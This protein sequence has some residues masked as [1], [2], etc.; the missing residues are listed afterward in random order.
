MDAI[1]MGIRISSYEISGGHKGWDHSRY[2]GELA[3]PPPVAVVTHTPLILISC[4][5]LQPFHTFYHSGFH[6][7]RSVKCQL[8][9]IFSLF[10]VS[11]SPAEV[12]GTYQEVQMCPFLQRSFSLPLW[13]FIPRARLEGGRGWQDGKVL[14]SLIYTVLS[15]P[16]GGQE[17]L[18]WNSPWLTNVSLVG[19]P[20]D[21][22]GHSQVGDIRLHLFFLNQGKCSG[23]H[24]SPPAVVT[25]A[26]LPRSASTFWR[27]LISLKSATH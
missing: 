2:K 17:G 7:S 5:T 8:H 6:K 23:P 21:F 15:E 16:F 3:L 18:T 4:I 22:P 13:I 19:H 24:S 26:C 25:T 10:N 27:K 12:Q 11:L 14:T 1:T 9:L 20:C